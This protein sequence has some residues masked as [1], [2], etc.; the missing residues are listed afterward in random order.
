MKTSTTIIFLCLLLFC[1]ATI[2][3]NVSESNA[4]FVENLSG[5]A[6]VP[7]MYLGAKHMVT[8]IDH[9]LYLVGILFFLNQTRDVLIYAT[10]FTLGHSL[11][12]ASGVILE[13]GASPF[14]IDAV[15]GLSIVYK[16][17]E[18]LDGFQEIFGFSF[19]PLAAVFVFGLAHGLGLA[20]KLQSIAPRNDALVVNILSFNVGVELGQFFAL[21]LM[22]VGAI[23]LRSRGADGRFKFVIN[24]ALMTAG[25][26]LSGYHLIGFVQL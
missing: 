16:A 12:L 1:E 4:R 6:V 18:N 25:F 5:Q 24:T 8:G 22:L 21:S 10:F 7:F 20:T 14:I 13:V 3:H 9:L 17:F 23:F 26:T 2:A 19:N 11:T 15:I